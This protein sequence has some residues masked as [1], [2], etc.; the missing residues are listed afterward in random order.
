[1]RLL[2]M[3]FCL[4]IA[5]CGGIGTKPQN[6]SN[7]SSEPKIPRIEK[8]AKQGDWDHTAFLLVQDLGRETDTARARRIA[9]ANPEAVRAI[10]DMLHTVAQ[11]LGNKTERPSYAI[12]TSASDVAGSLLDGA[13]TLA[14]EGG[15]DIARL[16][17]RIA[18]V[19]R[20]RL[21]TDLPEGT[22]QIIRN[23]PNNLFTQDDLL[24]WSGD[25]LANN[26]VP[27][28]KVALERAEQNSDFRTGLKEL[29]K[30]YGLKTDYLMEQTRS[31]YGETFSP[32]PE[33]IDSDALSVKGVPMSISFEAF[34]A[35]Y[36]TGF[37]TNVEGQTILG[38]RR[39]GL[40]D[41][42]RTFAGVPANL[43]FLFTC[44]DAK[45]RT[46]CFLYSVEVTFHT[47]NYRRIAATM[48]A[49]YGEADRARENVKENRMGAKFGSRSRIWKIRSV[50]ARIEERG[51]T[52][53]EGR[54]NY[55][56]LPLLDDARVDP[57]QLETGDI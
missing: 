34:K 38:C 7:R 18:A 8:A 2:V 11:T 15:Y 24:Q 27:V 29:L 54:V 3:I 9:R 50:R 52:V 30:N 5:G 48:A 33:P 43:S 4:S 57:S 36:N 44:D 40:E 16:K 26:N 6:T 31:I 42:D 35:D 25:A 56:F 14:E 47:R 10:P 46:G 53:D 23:N 32:Y 21:K 45:S 20:S 41:G 19:L 39:E 55:T 49:E 37:C 17:A 51:S 12:Y 13:E 22:A 1:M 28:I